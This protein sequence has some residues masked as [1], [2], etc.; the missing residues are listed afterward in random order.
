ME[1]SFEGLS[2]H[3]K[4]L[5]KHKNALLRNSKVSGSSSVEPEWAFWDEELV[6]AGEVLTRHR[7]AFLERLKPHIFDNLAQ[8]LPEFSFEISYY[9]GWEKEAS[10]K[11][12]IAKKYHRDAKQ[13]FLSVGP[14]KADLKFRIE[15]ANAAEVLSRGQLRML[16]A[17]LQ[18]SETQCLIE[19]TGKTSVF[20]L[21]DVGAELDA[22]KREKFIDALLR[23]NAQLFVTA[24]EKEQLLF[25]R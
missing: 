12:S 10:F 21:D 6:K 15:G 8:F 13:G 24:I 1:Q 3:Y 19:E 16:V 5:L 2:N 22:S 18:L 7:N 9:R 25:Y 11:E 4:R 23:F 20:L 17:A 14:H